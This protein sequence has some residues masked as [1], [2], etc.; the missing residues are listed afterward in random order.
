MVPANAVLVINHCATNQLL[1][2]D[3]KSVKNSFGVYVQWL[4]QW[5]CSAHMPDWIGGAAFKSVYLFLLWFGLALV[6]IESEATAVLMTA[7]APRHRALFPFF[8]LC[9][10]WATGHPWAW[11]LLFGACDFSSVMHCTAA[12]QHSVIRNPLALTAHVDSRQYPLGVVVTNSTAIV[13][14]AAAASG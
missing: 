7:A 4:C 9:F 13:C 11:R 14:G 3:N 8:P 6:G 12:V 10:S 2:S 5:L 1:S